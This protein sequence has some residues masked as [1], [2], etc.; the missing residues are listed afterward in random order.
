M[1]K[2]TKYSFAEGLAIAWNRNTPLH[3]A[4]LHAAGA[5]HDE[6]LTKQAWE[7][8]RDE[9]LAL[10]PQ[11]FPSGYVTMR[12]PARPFV[13]AHFPEAADYF[14]R[15]MPNRARK[16]IMLSQGVISPLPR[17]ISPADRAELSASKTDVA[18]RVVVRARSLD[19]RH[20]WSTCK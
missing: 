1:K 6:I 11:A 13:V 20:D 2:M 16:A 10:F 17:G 5:Q 4:F 9:G 14:W 7:T 18:T 8:L 19:K 12:R 3:V 15:G